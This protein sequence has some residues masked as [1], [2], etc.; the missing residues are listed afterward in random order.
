MICKL[1]TALVEIET[2]GRQLKSVGP[3]QLT[4]EVRKHLGI[5]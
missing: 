5:H 3:I 4:Y 2:A 1:E